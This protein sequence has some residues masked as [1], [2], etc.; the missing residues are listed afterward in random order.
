MEKDYVDY[1]SLATL[2][3]PQTQALQALAMRPQKTSSITTTTTTPR[4][5]ENMIANRDRIGQSTQELDNILKARESFKYRFGQGLANVTPQ[6]E[7]GAGWLSGFLRGVGGGLTGYVDNRAARA[8]QKYENEMK[9]LAEI[10]AFDKAMG[11]IQTQNQIMGYTPMEYGT[12]GGTKAAGGQGGAQSEIPVL[13]PEYW[14]QMI[15]NFDK[16][17]P[18]E[19]SYRAQSQARR[20]L[21][22]KTT[23]LGDPDEDYARDQFATAKGRDFLPMARNALKVRGKLQIL[24]IK[25]IH[26]G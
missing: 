2:L 6:D 19:A 9:D 15:A 24:K 1:G 18:T 14:D 10:L 5:L 11:D 26:N 13:N 4:A 8:Q 25:N 17:R 20:A 16:N 7:S 21:E 23:V 3:A 22:N 12:A